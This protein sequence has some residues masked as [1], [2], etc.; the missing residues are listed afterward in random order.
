MAPN[1]LACAVELP[2]NREMVL[3]YVYRVHIIHSIDFPDSP[4]SL[5]SSKFILVWQAFWWTQL[6]EYMIRVIVKSF[7]QD[8]CC[9]FHLNYHTSLMNISFISFFRKWYTCTQYRRI[10]R[11][12]QAHETSPLK[13]PSFEKCF[14]IKHVQ[15]TPPER[16]FSGAH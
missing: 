6:Q 2:S 7:Q 15:H 14:A 16:P 9:K 8:I 13:S 5:Y 12:R 11:E 1:R 3:K 10:P 4:I